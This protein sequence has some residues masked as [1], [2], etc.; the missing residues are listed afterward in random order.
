[1][2][3]KGTKNISSPVGMPRKGQHPGFRGILGGMYQLH[4]SHNK[5]ITVF[6]RFISIPAFGPCLQGVMRLHSPLL[7]GP[8]SSSIHPE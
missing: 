1:M 7:F 4:L 2:P 5:I 3:N 6:W 8:L